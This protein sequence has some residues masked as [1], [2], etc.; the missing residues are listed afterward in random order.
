MLFLLGYNSVKIE[1]SMIIKCYSKLLLPVNFLLYRQ[2]FKD[3]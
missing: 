2:L 3:I 1:I